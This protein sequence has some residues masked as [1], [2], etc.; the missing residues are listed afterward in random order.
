VPYNRTYY[1]YIM[2]SDCGT[3]YVGVTSNLCN[4]AYEHRTGKFPGFTSKYKV[5]KLVYWHSF[6][7]ITDAI[8]REKQIKRWRREKK[9]FLVEKM[10]PQW[11]DLYELALQELLHF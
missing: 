10:N 3:L 2:A 5:H 11:L 1:V 6:L 7:E 4:R 8:A 9:R